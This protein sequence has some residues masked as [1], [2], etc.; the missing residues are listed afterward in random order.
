MHQDK[1]VSK[2]ATP[3]SQ[4]CAFRNDLCAWKLF[5]HLIRHHDVKTYRLRYIQSNALQMFM[6]EFNKRLTKWE[7]VL[8]C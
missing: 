6:E 7:N 1:E 5:L 2:Y 4:T 8:K 3:Q